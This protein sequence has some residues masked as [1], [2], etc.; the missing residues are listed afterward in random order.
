M[1]HVVVLN[2]FVFPMRGVQ[3]SGASL[4]STALYP[5]FSVNFSAKK[6]C[7]THEF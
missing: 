1:P 5:V 2:V 3:A 4:S 7:A 6:T